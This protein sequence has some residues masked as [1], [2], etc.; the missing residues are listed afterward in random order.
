MSLEIIRVGQRPIHHIHTV[1]E[2]VHMGILGLKKLSRLVGIGE[3]FTPN[4]VPSNN[5][6]ESLSFIVIT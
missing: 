6:P 3:G 5:G 1:T 4:F 2:N